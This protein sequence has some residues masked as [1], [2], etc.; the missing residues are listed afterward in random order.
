LINTALK[1]SDGA[2]D[3]PELSSTPPRTTTASPTLSLLLLLFLINMDRNRI[4]YDPNNP[5]MLPED[6][7]MQLSPPEL[8]AAMDQLD[9]NLVLVLQ[10]I[11]ENFAACNQVVTERI[12]PAVEQHGE[13]SARIYESIKVRRI[14]HHFFAFL[15]DFHRKLQF[16]RP[17]FEAAA[18]T[19]LNQPYEEE[20]ESFTESDEPSQVTASPNQT[21]SDEG[22]ITYGAPSVGGTPRAPPP[23]A[24]A[25]EASTSGIPSEPQWSNDMSPY[26][27]LEADIEGGGVEGDYSTMKGSLPEVQRVRLRDLPPDSPDVPEPHFETVNVGNALA[28]AAKYSSD[29]PSTG[30]G[31]GRGDGESFELSSAGPS[32][33]SFTTA[34][35]HQSPAKNPR[36]GGDKA[37]SA[38]LH[39]I[40]RKNLASPARPP[41]HHGPGSSTPGH[42]TARKLKFP[43]DVPKNWDGIANLSQTALDAFPSPIKRRNSAASSIADNSFAQPPSSIRS[44]AIYGA[45]P[46]PPPPS[47]PTPSLSAST[48]SLR[49]HP[50]SRSAV[51]PSP[52]FTRTPA[53]DAARRTAQNVFNALDPFDL[54]DSPMLEPPSALRNPATTVYRFDAKSQPSRADEPDSPSER[55]TIRRPTAA[56]RSNASVRRTGGYEDESYN[57][58]AQPSFANASVTQAL[59]F[60][61]LANNPQADE[62]SSQSL[63]DFGG[64]TTANID[65][66][67]AGHTMT[68]NPHAHGSSN[69][70]AGIVN[71]DDEE[72]VHEGDSYTHTATGESGVPPRATDN[73][74]TATGQGYD[75]YAPIGGDDDDDEDEFRAAGRGLRMPGQDGPEDTLFGMPPANANAGGAAQAKPKPR[76][77]S[78]GAQ[79]SAQEYSHH[80]E[81]GEE[82][83]YEEED[84]FAEEARRSGFRL[85]GLSEME[86]LHGGELLSSGAFP[87]PPLFF[88]TTPLMSSSD[89]QNLF[90]R[91][92]WQGGTIRSDGG[93]KVE[94]TSFVFFAMHAGRVLP[95]FTTVSVVYESNK[96]SVV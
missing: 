4:F 6:E 24:S 96:A 5:V 64:G 95:V 26:Q 55:S 15:A 14:C 11:E 83:L 80:E 57:S 47:R 17:F 28:S 54:L 62:R 41:L 13:N 86:T 45:S 23:P 25:G 46:A 42:G 61:T 94:E 77:V 10:Q 79:L 87:L 2:Q 44:S 66:L 65:D 16:W 84:S 67:L 89:P 33:P 1:D 68:F 40:L 31:K 35:Q 9:Q 75:R 71:D 48:S 19:K 85:H 12:L 82:G 59:D 60:H 74:F 38:L 93:G 76:G 32:E 53:K 20:A 51:P 29:S 3:D 30:K 34:F 21:I 58:L 50:A 56:D 27:N 92:R 72:L 36:A 73:T 22:D 49:G 7:V 43:S 63:A 39:K 37:H 70:Y 88:Y 52:A 8:Q 81:E 91:V 69:D 78:F 18:S 90:R